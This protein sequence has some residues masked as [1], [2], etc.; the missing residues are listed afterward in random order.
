MTKYMVVYLEEN[1]LIVYDTI[2]ADTKDKALEEAC[3]RAK[4]RGQSVRGIYEK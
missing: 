1:G 3:R 4:E 2:E